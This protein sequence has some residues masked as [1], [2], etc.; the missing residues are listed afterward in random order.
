[1]RIVHLTVALLGVVTLLSSLTLGQSDCDE[2][3]CY[4][5]VAGDG[6]CEQLHREFARE[7]NCQTLLDRTPAMI[8]DFFV[9]E[10]T[11]FSGS[12]VTDRLMVVA[13]DLD[14]PN[15]LPGGGSTLV[16]TEPGPVGIFST[17]LSSIQDLQ[18]LLRAGAPLPAA[19][20]EGTIS[21]NA[22]M[23]TIA[24]V[25]QI[26]ALL[27]ST[28]EAFDIVALAN[29]PGTYDSV[30]ATLF[31]ARN[32]GPGNTILNSAASGAVLQGGVD[33]LTGGEDFDA[34]YFYEYQSAIRLLVP[35]VSGGGVGRI[36]LAEGGSV[37]PQD[38]VFFRYS[39]IDDVMFR[40]NGV[41]LSRFTPGFERTFYDGLFS[42]ELRVPFA[43]STV[44]DVAT[45]GAQ[46]LGGTDAQFGNLTMYLKALLYSRESCAF[47]AGLGIE[48]PTADG[49]S[50][51]LG[52]TPILD[53]SNDVVHLQP[54]FGVLHYMNEHV[55]GQGF[56]QFDLAAGSNDVRMNTSGTGL[57]A[58][59]TISD[60][61]YVFVDYAIGVWAM[62]NNRREGLTGIIPT[63]EF[64]HMSS[65]SGADIASAGGLTL[66]GSGGVSQTNF[67][68]GTTLEFGQN[69]HVSV[70][71][72]GE[73]DNE[74]LHGGAFRLM[75]NMLR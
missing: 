37:M 35:Q 69:K 45:N 9:G 73:L 39:Y 38:R 12:M 22:T 55:F 48:V 68:A 24:T 16:I 27:A 60:R 2:A 34:F 51:S 56:L 26:Q 50:M 75:V 21:D 14:A 49:I 53:V 59:G 4:S 54:F 64:H 30:V 29:P 43:S 13:N 58:A 62:R 10:S 57:T 17:S 5:C 20:L 66:G 52:G 25:S 28:P 18:T 6:H 65:I 23:T 63:V 19:T 15:P 47:T 46:I 71:Y 33:T 74:L 3:C 8:G 70:A 11:S 72:A 41:G 42:Y 44:S 31:A 67:V 36:K 40:T 1:M 61:D 7:K 32:T